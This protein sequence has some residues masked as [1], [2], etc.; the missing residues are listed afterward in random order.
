MFANVQQLG[1]VAVFQ[2]QAFANI[3]KILFKKIPF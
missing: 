1:E 2:H 3:D